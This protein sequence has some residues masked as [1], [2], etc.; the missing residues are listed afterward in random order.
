MVDFSFFFLFCLHM[1]T[2]YCLKVISE[3]EGE[4]E[5]IYIRK[6][7]FVQ[8]PFSKATYK[9]YSCNFIHFNRGSWERNYFFYTL[10]I[11]LLFIFVLF[12]VSSCSFLLQLI[13]FGMDWGS[14]FVFMD[15]LVSQFCL[16][17][18]KIKKVV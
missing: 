8:V 5:N 14:P 13:V 16:L 12:T 7:K 4:I 10:V 9:K 2:N 6:V 17:Y 3:K 18:I 15:H 11:C 1:W